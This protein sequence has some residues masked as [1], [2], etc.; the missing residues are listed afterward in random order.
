MH[1]CRDFCVREMLGTNQEQAYRDSDTPGFEPKLKA[2]KLQ[3]SYKRTLRK[4]KASKLQEP[5]TQTHT[6]QHTHLRVALNW[7]ELG[8]FLSQVW[9]PSCILAWKRRDESLLDTISVPSLRERVT[10]GTAFRELLALPGPQPRSWSC[11]AASLARGCCP[12]RP[13]FPAPRQSSR[14]GLLAPPRP[15][16]AWRNPAPRPRS[17]RV[18]GNR[19]LS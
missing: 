10:P 11:A 2:S 9:R 13:A 12:G 3:E 6:T 19:A 4:L 14:P 17:R 16:P 5:C 7:K 1:G 18:E 8:P 15:F